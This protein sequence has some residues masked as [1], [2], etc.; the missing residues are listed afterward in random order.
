[1]SNY[2]IQER[3]EVFERD[4][5][6]DFFEAKLFF[7]TVARAYKRNETVSFERLDAW[8]GSDETKGALWL[9]KDHSQRLYRSSTNNGNLYENLFDWTVGSIFHETIKLKEDAYQITS[10]KPLLEMKVKNKSY[11]ATL[12]S[13]I[14][15]YFVLIERAKESVPI[16]VQ[17]IGEL[18]SKALYHLHEIIFAARGNMLI[19]LLLLEEEKKASAVFG[20]DQYRE[21]LKRMFPEGPHTAWIAAG[22][23]YL[24]GGWHTQARP[25]IER[26]LE[27]QEQNACALELLAAISAA[28]E[29]AGNLST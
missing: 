13:I 21:L 4:L 6:Q 11:D 18:F 3:R 1:M 7:D 2:W 27:I 16:A 24:E 8:V 15:E 22:R 10:Y 12:G 17:N 19:L 9:L 28:E 5:I 14:Q 23:Y 29:K 20:R 26:A 25:C